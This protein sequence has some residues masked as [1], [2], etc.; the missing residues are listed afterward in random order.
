V[1]VFVAPS[2]QDN[3]PNTVMEAMACG[4][5]SIAFNIGG[6]PDMI[7]HK[8]NGYLAEPFD[9]ADFAHGIRWILADEQRYHTLAAQA[10]L[11]AEIRFDLKKIAARYAALYEEITARKR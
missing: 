4:T 3:L 9:E 2:I 8:Q 5:P 7:D 6:M 1:D 11:D 10:R